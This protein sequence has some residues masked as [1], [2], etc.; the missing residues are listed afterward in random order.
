MSTNILTATV[1]ATGG[2]LMPQG[3]VVVSGTDGTRYASGTLTG[4]AQGVSTATIPWAA[5]APAGYQL[6]ATYVPAGGNTVASTSSMSLLMA[7]ATT[8]PLSLVLPTLI[9]PNV[10]I[11][12]GAV[13]GDPTLGGTVAFLVNDNGVITY[14]GGSLN[15]TAGSASRAWTPPHAGNFLVTANY[16]ALNGTPTASISQVI[17]ARPVGAPDPMSVTVGGTAAGASVRVAAGTRTPVGTASGSGAPV[18]LTT[19]GPCVL[20]GP[21][22]VA[23][24][25]GSCLL[26]ASSPGAGGYSPN[27]ASFTVT[28]G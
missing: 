21:I 3:T 16:T 4:S 23:V 25:K 5:P 6:V 22:L 10:P 1:V 2:V 18:N 28:V 9:T 8:P 20:A 19:S 26:A 11:T 13:V 27:T 14:L 7:Q 17:A 12:I 15:L 24:A